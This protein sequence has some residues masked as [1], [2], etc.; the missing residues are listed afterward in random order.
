[1]YYLYLKDNES[2]IVMTQNKRN[3]PYVLG[4]TRNAV[5][6][7]HYLRECQDPVNFGDTAFT[8]CDGAALRE[9]IG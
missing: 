9:L 1:M 7:P 4:C 5:I 3:R 6:S 2:K 8:S